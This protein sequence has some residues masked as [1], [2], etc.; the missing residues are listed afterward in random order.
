M[1]HDA[2][3][4]DLDAGT[5]VIRQVNRPVGMRAK[6]STHATMLLMLAGLL[7]LLAGY[8]HGS[9]QPAPSPSSSSGIH[10]I[11]LLA[12]GPEV[13][14]SAAPSPLAG[15]FGT[16]ELGWPYH[17]A[18]IVV[19]SK[20][21]RQAPILVTPALNGLFTVALPPGTYEL[22]AKVPSDGPLPVRRTVVVKRGK[23]TRA[24]V[25]VSAF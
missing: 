21:G 16:T 22:M 19:T 15:G 4:T 23:F 2:T 18:R 14:V 12:G 17:T 10:G 6:V 5:A 3:G 9:G 1:R 8:G 11:L 25:Y 24:R 7:L 13:A 20:S